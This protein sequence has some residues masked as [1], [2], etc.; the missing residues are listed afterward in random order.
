[1]IS[2]KLRENLK[3]AFVKNIEIAKKSKDISSIEIGS[4]AAVLTIVD[5]INSA[6]PFRMDEVNLK[7][8][9]ESRHPIKGLFC[10]S[11]LK[12][13]FRQA[14]VEDLS[15]IESYG[16][17]KGGVVDSVYSYYL[18]VNGKKRHVASMTDVHLEELEKLMREYL[19]RGLP[20]HTGTISK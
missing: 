17:Y 1:M 3:T 2:D 13:C 4:F 7:E 18:C 6:M 12:D 10:S 8:F 19:G 5:Y 11:V 15:D 9:G 20:L 16:V 14:E